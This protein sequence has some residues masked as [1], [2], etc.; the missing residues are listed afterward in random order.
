MQ[1][2]L[3]FWIALAFSL[4]LVPLVRKISLRFGL[5][6]APKVDRW[7][8][9]PT[10]KV[11]GIAM[12]AAFAL[13]FLIAA[14]IEPPQEIHWAL[15]VG[16]L[17]TFS[18]GVLDD[19]KH[20][21]PAAKLIGQIIAAAIVVFFGRNLDFFDLEIL[22]I[23]FT[24]GWLIGITNAI[25][26][27]DNMD[28]LAGGVALIAALALSLMFWQIG[29]F[30]LLL[31][32]LAL[33]GSILG[34]LVFNF[35]PASIF[36]GDAGSLFLGFTLASLAIAQV[37]RASNLLA[38]LGVPTLIFLLP[39]LDTTMVTIT[40][41]LRG[42]S[43]AQGGRD[44]T[45]HRLIAFGLSERQTV[46]ALYGVALLS[47]IL[48][49]LLESIDYNISL[50]LIPLLLLVMTL[51]TAFLGRIKVVKSANAA[52]H[53]GMMTR[54]VIGL[55][56]RGRILEIALDLVIISVAYYLAFWLYYGFGADVISINIFV[57][58]LPLA[59]V[60][61]Y[62]SFFAFGI[63]S[64]VWQYISLSDLLR[65][66]WAVIGCGIFIGV[67]SVFLYPHQYPHTAIFLFCVFLFLGLATSRASFRFLD[68][69]Y[70]RQTHITENSAAVFIFGAEDAGVMAQQW[71]SNQSEFKYK[72]AGFL[73][74]DPFKRGRQIFGITV[75][76]GLD[77]LESIIIKNPVQGIILPSDEMLTNFQA[78]ADALKIC[79]K[80]GI[81]LK[82]LRISFENIE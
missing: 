43:P 39:I 40:R 35:P 57:N 1:L 5:V 81:W 49:T 37:P 6:D 28:G 65:F 82:R 12:F 34:F 58:S 17:I 9:R 27:L 76:G 30:N 77:D 52:E 24:F 18:L 48:G 41:I 33:G 66:F 14:L 38:I 72:V 22:N 80:H 42:Q 60:A 8:T 13:A 67:S 36:M 32:S 11:G 53:P 19:F 26:L 63:Y 71:L 20:L 51:L 25:N 78:S 59:L 54:L 56:G 46:L 74:N 31:I 16:S 69:L 21:S 7:H 61:A 23:I 15:L 4:L 73:D 47:G 75:L 29:A 62:I 70:N 10:P 79:K 50:I 55:T 2:T 68:Q 44:H 45:S 64:G 3:P